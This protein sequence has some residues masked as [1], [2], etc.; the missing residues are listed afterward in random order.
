MTAKDWEQE[1]ERLERVKAEILRQME[2]FKAIVGNRR[3]Q[4]LD[5]RR[6]FWDDISINVENF[7]EFMEAHDSIRQQTLVLH[8][9]ERAM[10]HAADSLRKLRRQLDSPYFGR[11]DFAVAGENHPQALYIGLATL[12]AERTGESLIYDWRAPV[13]QLFYD[14]GLGP[15]HYL[16]PE[17]DVSGE[18]TGKRQFVIRGGRL[19]NM[20]DTGV[21]IVDQMLQH[22]LSRSADERM[23]TIVT[24]IQKEQNE[25]IREDR[26][27]LVIVQGVAGSGKTS[28]ALQRIAYLLYKYRDTLDADHMLLFSPND[29][30]NDYVS[31]VLPELGERNMRQT[32]F[33]SYLEHR[34]GDECGR[35]EDAYDQLEGLLT[36]EDDRRHAILLA[37]TR[38]K[39][40]GDYARLIR[41]Y[42]ELLQREGLQFREYRAG[43]KVVLSGGELGDLFYAGDTHLPVSRRLDKLKE[44]IEADLEVKEKA[45]MKA[46]YRKL[47][48][49]PKYIGTEQELKVQSKRTIRKRFAPLKRMTGELAFV[50]LGATYR[51]LFTEPGL[52][53]RLAAAAG[54]SLPE[55]WKDLCAYTLNRLEE[56]VVPYEDAVALLYL[57]ELIEGVRSFLGIRHLVVDEAQ[58]YSPF[59]YELFRRMFPRARMTLLGDWNQGIYPHARRQNYD[60]VRSLFGEEESRLYRLYKS[61]RSTREIVEFTRAILPDGERVEAFS[62]TGEA[63]KLRRTGGREELREVLL[64][65]IRELMSRGAGSLAVICRTDAESLE[66]FELLKDHVPAVRITKYTKTFVSGLLVLPVYL[67]KGLEFDAVLVY[68]AGAGAYRRESERKLLY[69]ACTRAMHH[70]NLYTMG[71]PSPLL[72]EALQSGVAVSF[73]RC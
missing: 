4:V 22:M 32:T 39:A 13:S 30:F 64:H 21:H 72:A 15:A 41:S 25:I 36:A 37:G 1:T 71:E 55:V 5:I 53:E 19:E 66:A 9:E 49:Y 34:L 23:K 65:D 38:W 62:R 67:A 44:W 45:M 52:A 57:K 42:A 12:L 35:L 40:S 18:I 6:N 20:F 14:F 50:D 10:A 46:Y 69:T 60:F 63:P 28:V 11:V 43:K 61:Y 56:G 16:S 48:H 26:Y 8:N 70:L 54:V 3:T 17:G 27:P 7:E 2:R 58:D 31:N 51:R 68:N 29:L 59:H 33:Q 47:L 73:H 24:T